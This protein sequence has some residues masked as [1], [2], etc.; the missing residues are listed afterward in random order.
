MKLN[1][2]IGVVITAA[3]LAL[4]ITACASSSTW[5]GP[6]TTIRIGHHYPVEQA[7]FSDNTA[8]MSRIARLEMS[9]RRYAEKEVMNKLGVKI[10][11]VQYSDLKE[12]LRNGAA[13]GGAFDLV[14]IVGAQQGE[15]L[16]LKLLQAIDDYQNVFAD[17]DSSW[18][19]WPKVFGHNYFLNMVLRAGPDAPLVYNITMLEKVPALKENGKTVLPVH[20]WKQ[21]KW[22]WSAFEDYLQKVHDHWTAEW[23]GRIAYDADVRNAVLLALYANGA[24]VLNDK[25]LQFDT[26]EAKAAVAFI[27]RLMAKRLLR[28]PDIK[29]GTS[30][31][32]GIMDIWR[33]QWGHSV[34]GNLQQWLSQDMVGAFNERR[35][36]M[37][38]VPFPRPD[39]LDANDPAYQQ[40]NDARD[41]YAVPAGVSADKVDLALKAFKEYTLSFYK[42]LA[43]SD[44]ALDFLQGDGAKVSAQK[45]F[46]D[47]SSKDYGAEMLEVWKFMGSQPQINEYAK[48]A[49]LWNYWGST[50]LS[51]SLYQVNGA[52]AY[53]TWADEKLP[54]AQEL[55]DQIQEALDN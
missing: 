53:D 48:N 45:M 39:W 9:A 1:V 4:A 41:C 49:G 5:T 40:A 34:F 19:F 13:D 42:N 30:E 7:T 29:E 35:E 21:G 55:L 6:V 26:E 3:A 2:R 22:T 46:I 38:I 11:W 54:R 18:I 43:N 52:S 27:D 47:I 15:L 23:D 37:G 10:E 51:D 12:E 8:D 33:F 28:N 32:D 31:Q 50:I 24:G 36:K 14:R 44:K 20:L 17:T 16:G 25:G